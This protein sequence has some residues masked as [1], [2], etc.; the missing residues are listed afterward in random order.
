[1]LLHKGGRPLPARR[2]TGTARPGL[3]IFD[4]RE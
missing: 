2:I 3:T 1:M 4:L